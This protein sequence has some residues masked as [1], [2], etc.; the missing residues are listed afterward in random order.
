MPIRTIFA[1][2]ALLTLA[3]PVAA[4][5]HRAGARDPVAEKYANSR[6][7]RS[8]PRGNEKSRGLRCHIVGKGRAAHRVCPRPMRGGRAR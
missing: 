5:D 7:Y 2:A 3:A 4:Q 6:Q 1:A 8:E